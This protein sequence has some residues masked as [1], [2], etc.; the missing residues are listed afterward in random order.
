[1]EHGLNNLE[2]YMVILAEEILSMNFGQIWSARW[3]ESKYESLVR[4]HGIK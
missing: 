1:M 2:A 4:V 3:P